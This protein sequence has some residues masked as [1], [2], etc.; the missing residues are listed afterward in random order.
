MNNLKNPKKDKITPNWDI[1]YSTYYW[2]I[3]LDP[4]HKLNNPNVEKLTGYSKKEFQNE[5]QDIVHLL[6]SKIFNLNKN[7][8]FERMKKIIIYSRHGEMIKKKTDPDILILFPNSFNIPNE[9]HDYIFK[10]FGAFLHEF[11]L[12]KRDNKSMEGLIPKLR[13]RTSNDSFLDCTKQNFSSLSQLY[14]YCGRL[15]LHGHS[16]G[17]VN[18]F[19]TKYKTLKNW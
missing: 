7:G 16:E 9:N 11:Y 17:E 18:H 10:R 13:Q 3:Y 12:R 6:K 4:L 14:T 5:G 1:H 19:I 8:Y 2:E 15:L